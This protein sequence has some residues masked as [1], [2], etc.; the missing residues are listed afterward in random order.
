MGTKL[1]RSRVAA[2]F[3][4]FSDLAGEHL[5]PWRGFCETAAARVEARLRP[6]ADVKQEMEALCIAA[7]A[8]AYCDYL[9]A[10]EAGGDQKALRVGDISIQGASGDRQAAAEIRDYFLGEAAHLLEPA[11]PALRAVGGAP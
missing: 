1:D 7:A 3:S 8:W 2:V 9:M 11:C 4:L 5:E 6:G 10:S